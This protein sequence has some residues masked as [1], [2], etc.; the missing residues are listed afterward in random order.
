VNKIKYYKEELVSKAKFHITSGHQTVMANIQL[1]G[2]FTNEAELEFFER[3]KT[4]F[5]FNNMGFDK[6]VYNKF[7]FDREY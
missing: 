6:S 1:F 5:N 3:I 7:N 2:C 4:K